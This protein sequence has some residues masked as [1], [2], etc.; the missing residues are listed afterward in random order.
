MKILVTTYP[1]TETV[2]FLNDQRTIYNSFKRKMSRIELIE[3][4]KKYNPT[5]IIAGTEKY[6]SEILDLCTNLKMISRVGTGLDSIDLDECKKRNIT[7]TNTPDAQTKAVA[8]LTV[9]EMLCMCRN[10]INVSNDLKA[11]KW[12]RAIGLGLSLCK[13]GIIGFGRIGQRVCKLLSQFGCEIMVND[14]SLEK[15]ELALQMGLDV[16]TKMEIYQ[17]CN[18]VTLH[19]PLT[20]E[21]HNMIA[22]KELSEFKCKMILNNSRGGIINEN[23]IYTW[24]EEN[25]S[26]MAAIDTFEQEPYTG[27]LCS[28][29]NI[30]ITPHIGSCTIDARTRMENDSIDNVLV[31]LQSGWSISSIELP[32]R[33]HQ[34]KKGEL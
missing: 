28:L 12:N 30:I 21:T 29:K 19:V 17:Q 27:K 14:I 4:L 33:T 2:P 34:K 24:L 5:I 23:D 31:F 26:R 3:V 16:K 7:V 8:E 6:D 22:K 1:F 9:A 15:K 32:D 10:L 18:I 13:V 20:N 25:G 11:F